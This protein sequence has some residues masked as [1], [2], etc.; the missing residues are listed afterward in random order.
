M[1]I[2]MMASHC[3]DFFGN[4]TKPDES[5]LDLAMPSFFETSCIT[6]PIPASGRMSG[7]VGRMK[8]L[9]QQNCSRAELAPVSRPESPEATRLMTNAQPQSASMPM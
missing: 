6:L 2:N 4:E 1:G 5:R 3:F 7:S 8:R 9:K